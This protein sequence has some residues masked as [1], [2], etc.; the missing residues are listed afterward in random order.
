ATRAANASVE[1]AE[2]PTFE[3]KNLGML[4]DLLTQLSVSKDI[5]IDTVTGTT[6]TEYR[7]YFHP[8]DEPS[9]RGIGGITQTSVTTLLN[10]LSIAD[11]RDDARAANRTFDLKKRKFVLVRF[12]KLEY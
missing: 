6:A 1:T 9:I 12:V 2:A 3:Q 7:V 5:R 11:Q 8:V 4:K 10:E